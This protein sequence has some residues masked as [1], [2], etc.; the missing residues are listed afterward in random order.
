[1]TDPDATPISVEISPG[2]PLTGRLTGP[3]G[4]QHEFSGWIGL[5]AALE[6]ALGSVVPTPPNEGAQHS[7]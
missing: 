3:D 2:D 7:C 4:I 6:R 5:A 1:M